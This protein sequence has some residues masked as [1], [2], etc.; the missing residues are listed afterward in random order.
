MTAEQRLT[1]F[2]QEARGPEQDPV[3]AAEVMRQVARREL[4]MRLGVSAVLA[5]GAAL[6]LWASAPALSAIVEPASRML[7]PVA[8]ILTLTAAFVVISQ[9]LSLLRVRS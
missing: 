1:A 5:T 6:G 2:L 7:S 9:N 8:A 3:F 4:A